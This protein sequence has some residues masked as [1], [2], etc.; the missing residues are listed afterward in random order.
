VILVAQQ[1]VAT[2]GAPGGMVSLGVE[3]LAA[4]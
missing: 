1:Q 4:P 3:V 2:W